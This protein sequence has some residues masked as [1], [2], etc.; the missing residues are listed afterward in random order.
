MPQNCL[1]DITK[2]ATTNEI[3]AR[4][5]RC[6]GVDAF[7][8]VVVRSCT[9]HEQVVFTLLEGVHYIHLHAEHERRDSK[10]IQQTKV[11]PVDSIC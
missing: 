1:R 3:L 6:R 9:N 2:V 10:A 7:Q 8:G 4:R 11:V 5:L